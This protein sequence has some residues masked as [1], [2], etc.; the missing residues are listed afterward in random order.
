M[1]TLPSL[2]IS[3][4]LFVGFSRLRMG[5]NKFI[6]TVASATFGVY[7]IHENR[8]VRPFLWD[9]VLRNPSYAN[10]GLLV[11]HTLWA[12][13]AVFIVCTVIELVRIRV[14][15][16]SYMPAVE[17]LAAFI[18]RKLRSLAPEKLLDK[19]AQR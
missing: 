7:L 6:N 17:K 5:P 16:K 8:F 14:I 18:D 3:V 11:P 13:A 15:E 4:L 9:T 1:K 2:V 10:S 12:I 19:L